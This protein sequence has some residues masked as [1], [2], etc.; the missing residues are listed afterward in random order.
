MKHYKRKLFLINNIFIILVLIFPSRSKTQTL[1]GGEITYQN[2][3]VD[4]YLVNLNLYQDCNGSS[5]DTF[6]LFVKCK[7]TSQMIDTLL[8]VNPIITNVTPVC[9][10]SC[11]RCDSANCIVPYGFSKYAFSDTL[12]FDS[13]TTC[14]W[15]TLYV[16][17]IGARPNTLTTGMAGRGFS[18]Y[19]EFNKCISQNSSPVFLN[20]PVYIVPIGSDLSIV[21]AAID[22]DTNNSLNKNDSISYVWEYPLDNNRQYL[23][24][25]GNYDYNKPLYFW[26]FPNSNLPSPRGLHLDEF[27]GGIFTRT[28]KVE[29]TTFSIESREYRNYQR[30]GLVHRNYFLQVVRYQNNS[31]PYLSG[32]FYKEVCEGEMVSFSVRTND[33]DPIDSL[34]IEIQHALPGATV[35][36]NNG[37]K[38]HPTANLSWQTRVGDAKNIPYYFYAKVKDDKCPVSAITERVYQ[39]KVLKPPKTITKI[40]DSGCNHFF[41]DYSVSGNYKS[42][43]WKCYF[44]DTF[45]VNTKKFDYVF[46]KPDTFYTELKVT[47]SGSTP[48]YSEIWDTI[49]IPPFPKPVISGDT[50]VCAGDSISIIGQIQNNHPGAFYFWSTGDSNTFNI[51]LNNLQKDTTVV[52][53]V[54]DTNGCIYSDEMFIKVNSNPSVIF[55]TDKTLCSYVDRTLGAKLIPQNTLVKEQYWKDLTNNKIVSSSDVY[56][57]GKTGLYEYSLVDENGCIAKDTIDFRLMELELILSKNQ[58]VCKGDSLTLWAGTRFSSGNVNY[59][60]ENSISNRTYHIPLNDHDHYITI[61]INDSLGCPV[62]DSVFID[63]HEVKVNLGND[64]STCIN[65]PL[66]IVPKYQLNQ[67]VQKPIFQWYRSGIAGVIDTNTFHKTNIEDTFWLKITDDIGCIGADTMFL[68]VHQNLPFVDAGPNDTFCS[69]DNF[70]LLQNVSNTSWYGEAVIFNKGKYYFNPRYYKLSSGGKTFIYKKIVDSN[71]CS[72]VD[73]AV[74]AVFSSDVIP[75]AGDYPSVCQNGEA[76]VLKGSP[77]GGIWTGE[78]VIQGQYFEPK[79]VTPGE[80]VLGYTAGKPHCLKTD[81]TKIVVLDLPNVQV[82]TTYGDTVFCKNQGIIPLNYTPKGGSNMGYWQGDVDTT[83]G[84]YFNTNKAVGY[85]SIIYTFKDFDNCVNSDTLTMKIINPKL[86]IIDPDTLICKGD[87]A[88]YFTDYNFRPPLYW[89]LKNPSNAYFIGSKKVANAKVLPGKIEFQ[90]R[91]YWIFVQAQ[92]TSCGLLRDSIYTYIAAHPKADFT[93]NQKAGNIPL[94]IYFQD[95]SSIDYDSIVSYSWN[96]G[97][98]GKSTVKSP[99]YTYQ[100]EGVY[101]VELVVVSDKGCTDMVL[102]KDY[103]NAKSISVFEEAKDGI[104]VFPNPTNEKLHVTSQSEIAKIRIFNQMGG[105]LYTSKDSG[106]YFEINVSKFPAQVF[107]IK[108]ELENGELI[109]RKVVKE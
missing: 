43:N 83:N 28:M 59:L 14:C 57:V 44:D 109:Y 22:I 38:K 70:E 75:I 26:G 55:T 89:S 56:L 94:E 29:A 11:T 85:Y 98:G 76:I 8:M 95:K 72:V 16:K 13:N 20:P 84:A 15:V 100:N 96:F 80:Y 1:L 67:T 49:I 62:K 35:G 54:Q 33:Y 81:Y 71:N 65:A 90:N 87:T 5:A 58:H 4:S 74:R 24:Y 102:K 48:C 68:K 17:A 45:I 101:D 36:T 61:E 46:T 34:I 86:K 92:D 47:S 82:N 66:K 50:F 3:G 31:A 97:D 18:V 23:P 6:K 78:G 53:Y 77:S 2:I 32:P 9:S 63:V 108:I 105:I 104:S 51:Q 25:S 19:S 107:I 52:F 7:G 10:T 91:G 42:I 106:K 93:S 79:L 88:K 99:V 21:P 41:F 103:T 64:I 73:S 30:I 27:T 60:W 12:I 40:S 39:I 69:D 37:L